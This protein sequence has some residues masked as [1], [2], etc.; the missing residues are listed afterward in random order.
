MTSWLTTQQMEADMRAAAVQIYEYLGVLYMGR[1][2]KSTLQLFRDAVMELE[3]RLKGNP[4]L[5]QQLKES[6]HKCPK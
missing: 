2:E 1:C 4:E 6:G 5:A 3:K